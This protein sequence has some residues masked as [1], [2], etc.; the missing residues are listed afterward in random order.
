MAISP[1]YR[2]FLED[3]FASFGPIAIRRMF[4][5]AGLFRDGLMFALVANDTL[6]LK[7]ND[8]NQADFEERGMG[9]FTYLRKSKMASLRYFQVPA[10]ILEDPHELKPWAE[11][12]FAVALSAAKSK[13][14]KV[15]GTRKRSSR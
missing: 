14:S 13:T 9:P 1:E 15:K 5:G 7:V 4:G 2:E 11:K 3:Q 8:S 10:E 6:Y 12:A